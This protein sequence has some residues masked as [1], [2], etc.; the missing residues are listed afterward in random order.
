MCGIF[1]GVG[2]LN[3]NRIVALGSMNEERGT[4]SVGI[5]Y[6]DGGEIRIAKI[7]ERPCV[8]L[9]LSLRK[10][11]T[12]AAVSGLFIG[13]TRAATQGDITSENAHPFLMEGIAF[14]HNGIII[15]DEDF[16]KYTVDSQSLIHGIKG[17]DFSKYEG[18]IALVWIEGGKLCAYRCGN[19]LYRGRHGDATYLASD[20][21]YLEAIGC[22]HIKELAEG[23][24]YTFHDAHNVTTKRVPKNKA[25]AY[26]KNWQDDAPLTTCQYSAGASQ[27]KL[28]AP[29]LK[30][31]DFP[32]V[33]NFDTWKDE[34]EK[35]AANYDHCE[36][37]GMSR[38]G[39]TE[40]CRDC[41]DWMKN[42]IN[43]DSPSEVRA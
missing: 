15:N 16:G 17:K 2:K 13:H 39:D 23:M 12:A 28:D 10:E 35:A 7:A 19:P 22:K 21:A 43:A 41:M 20:D 25:Y 40:Y 38:S 42:E 29:K 1:A 3:S 11:V 30:E 5:G 36:M 24:I 32:R 33:E 4:D 14:A 34:R 18:G 26:K 31:L 6:I 27:W 9:N 37:C 8:G